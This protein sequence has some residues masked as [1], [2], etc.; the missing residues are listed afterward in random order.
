M[1]VR[2]WVIDGSTVLV[3]ANV[4]T[5]VVVDVTTAVHRSVDRRAVAKLY[6]TVPVLRVEQNRGVP[7]TFHLH[8]HDERCLVDG[9]RVFCQTQTI[10][11]KLFYVIGKF[12]IYHSIK[13]LQL[14]Q[15]PHRPYSIK[16]HF[17]VFFIYKY[18]PLFIACYLFMLQSKLE[19]GTKGF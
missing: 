1:A 4:A 16:H 18:P 15:L 11:N 19:Q 5:V 14:L 3:D 7:W 6:L 13:F 17:Y 8:K 10:V 2:L 12:L 9:R